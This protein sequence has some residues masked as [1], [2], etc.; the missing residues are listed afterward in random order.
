MS[1]DVNSFFPM[2]YGKHNNQICF[3]AFLLMLFLTDLAYNLFF[4]QMLHFLKRF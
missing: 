3:E 2:N 1:E 4:F